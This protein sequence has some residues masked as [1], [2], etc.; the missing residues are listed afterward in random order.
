[1]CVGVVTEVCFSVFGSVSLRN[2][3]RCVTYSKHLHRDL[4]PQGGCCTPGGM[5]SE[6]E[7]F[8]FIEF[9]QLIV[10]EGSFVPQARLIHE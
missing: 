7:G 5:A 2:S 4:S 6:L 9:Q 3:K 10:C 1:M 8:L